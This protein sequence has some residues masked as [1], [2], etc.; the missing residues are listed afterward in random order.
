MKDRSIEDVSYA[1]GSFPA[2]YPTRER[3]AGPAA[4]VHY[5]LPSLRDI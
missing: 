2:I 1:L 4:S 5:D 3:F